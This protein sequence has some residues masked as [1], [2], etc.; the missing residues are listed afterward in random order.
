M[1][2]INKDIIFVKGFTNGAIY[3]FNDNKVYSVN[4]SACNIIERYINNSNIE[5]DINYLNILTRHK[6][7][8]KSFLPSP[9]LIKNT[10]KI[11]LEMTWIEITQSC[12]LR[13]IHC[14]EGTSHVNSPK[15][16]SLDQ[17]KNVIDQL[18]GLNIKRLI[19]IGGEPCCSS[20]ICDIIDYAST[21]KINIT[22]FTNATLISDDI[23]KCIIKNKIQVKI[24]I[25]GYCSKIHDSIT[26]I[27]GSFN[28]TVSTIKKLISA[29]IKV[30]SAFIVMKEN[31][32]FVDKTIA[33]IKNLGMYYSRY[34]IIRKTWKGTQTKHIP[35]Q[36]NILKYVYRTKPNF[37]TT[38]E[39]FIKNIF[40]N[41]CWYGK[42]SIMDNGDVIPCE[43]ERSFIYGNVLK[44]SIKEIIT[45]QRTKSRWFFNFSKIS[46][47]KYCEFRY[48]CQDCRP[49]G[50]SVQG[51]IT[52]KN[53]RCL[54]NVYTG[55]WNSLS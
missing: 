46:E 38:K 16:L 24:S 40:H 36:K 18:Y 10:N 12:N 28:K 30:F 50:I 44:Q 1:F 4:K 53:P 52:T 43:F 35:I 11:T 54:Y 22:L 27:P 39:N 19:I 20:I 13:C 34:D 49:L 51:K 42:I 29:K 8:S 7:I 37:K 31:E 55:K 2:E 23:L 3:N 47:C 48:A 14:Y 26:G 15:S 21:Y 9:Y 25:Y 6:L 17:W 32:Q 41:S 45:N 5:S 33:F